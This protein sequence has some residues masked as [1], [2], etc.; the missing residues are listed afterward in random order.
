MF[1]SH[2]LPIRRRNNK[3]LIR[4]N[5]VIDSSSASP[6]RYLSCLEIQH[7]DCPGT[8]FVIDIK[9]PARVALD[10]MGNPPHVF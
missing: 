8:L 9:Q 5:Y 2:Y 1:A 3:I 7:L 6:L 4:L 10:L